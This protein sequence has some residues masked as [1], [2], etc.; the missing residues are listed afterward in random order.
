[1]W[2][3]EKKSWI[4]IV[5]T[6]GAA[7]PRIWLRVL[8]IAVLSV[9]VTI[10]YEKVE[11]FHVNLTTT[12]FVL[13]GLPLGIFLGFRNTSAYDRFWEGRKLWGGIVNVTRSLTRQV[14]TM[15][16]SDAREMPPAAALAEPITETPAEVVAFQQRF[17]HGVVA[18]VH[19]L[20]LFL[21]EQP[22][23]LSGDP[24]RTPEKGEV[25]HMTELL[26]RHAR[27]IN[28]PV[29]ILQELGERLLYARRRGWI[30]P[31]YVAVLEAS[32][33]ELTDLQGA[34]ER[35]KGTPIPFSYTVL[36]H[37]IVAV[38]C[39]LLPFGLV[40]TIK[41]MTPVVVTFVSYALLGLD[42][43][44]DEIEQ[45]FGMETNDLPLTHLSKSIEAN[46]RSRLHEA[47]VPRPPRP[48]RGILH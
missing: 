7:L 15:V 35:I 4:R 25:A 11:A 8:T 34:C 10:L 41:W 23:S 27:D 29:A 31:L 16:S 21:R 2:V 26:E 14:L 24:A 17:V 38:Y 5:M 32:L 30:D 36:L 47:E 9:A 43:V 48:K 19:A 46:L 22:F 28:P 6:S 12:P 45:P 44:G 37:R 18:W 39:T 13:I 1:M 33:K 42:A 40:E 3:D 20:R